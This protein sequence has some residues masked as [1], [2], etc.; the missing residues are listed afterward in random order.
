MRRRG[1]WEQCWRSRNPL[2]SGTRS[3]P[4]RSGAGLRLKIWVPE[5]AEPTREKNLSEKVGENCSILRDDKKGAGRDLSK[6]EQ[7]DRN[8]SNCSFVPNNHMMFT[9]LMYLPVLHFPRGLR[10]FRNPDFEPEPGAL[11]A[12]AAPE[13]SG[14]PPTLVSPFFLSVPLPGN[15]PFR[16]LP[17]SISGPRPSLTLSIAIRYSGHH[18]HVPHVTHPPKDP[19]N[20]AEI[21]IQTDF[22]F[23]SLFRPLYPDI[24]SHRHLPTNPRLPRLH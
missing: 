7:N 5:P 3:A 6:H 17:T 4:E 9:H 11:R 14:A 15:A 21:A 2:G 18:G 8:A 22:P 24:T 16:P 13:R 10:G 12:P 23:I 19:V 20:G 1:E